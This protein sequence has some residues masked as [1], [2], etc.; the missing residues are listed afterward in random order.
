MKR[1]FLVSLLLCLS[2]LLGGAV[3]ARAEARI[4]YVS[5]FAGLLSDS[6]RQSLNERA[7]LVSEQYGF[8]V[9]VVTVS[10]YTEYVR[11]SIENFA[12]EIFHSYG[13]GVGQNEDG[14]VLALSMRERD[15]DIYAHGYGNYAFTDYGKARLADAFLDNFA[16]GDWAGG[17]RDYIDACSDM[18][19]KAREGNPVDTWIPDPAEQGP[20][21]DLFKLLL[22]LLAGCGVGGA[23]VTGMKRQMKGAVRQSRAENYIA[24][25]GV[26]LHRRE[27]EFVN[28][29][30]NRTPL[31]K[32]NSSGSRPGGG[33]YGG[34]TIS[35]S[36]G[37]SHHSGK[38]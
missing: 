30:V 13:L 5:D 23:S 19:G 12:E 31:P 29:V 20:R 32:Q 22:S 36:H 38:F 10:D 26:N 28:R 11:G 8:G 9:F 35:G 15:Y 18:L 7:R 1:K 21:F 25:G 16:R 33:H 27:D 14:V 3:F 6:E 4:D 2:L 37:G 24:R 34:T 17:V